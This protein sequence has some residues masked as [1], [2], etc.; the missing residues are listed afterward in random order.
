MEHPTKPNFPRRT[1]AERSRFSSFDV[2]LVGFFPAALGYSI[3]GN[4]SGR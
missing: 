4:K 1:Y 2:V 3:V